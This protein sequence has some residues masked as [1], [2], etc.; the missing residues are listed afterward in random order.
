MYR[1]KETIMGGNVCV[2]LYMFWDFYRYHK[3]SQ[4]LWDL[5]KMKSLQGQSQI[6]VQGI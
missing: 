4:D 1:L 5:W 3:E 2:I 6:I